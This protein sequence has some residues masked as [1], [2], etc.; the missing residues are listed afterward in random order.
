MQ[1][2]SDFHI[3]HKI[4]NKNQE[5]QRHLIPKKCLNLTYKQITRKRK[6]YSH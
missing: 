6:I 3:V 5:D 1:I 4:A 2:N